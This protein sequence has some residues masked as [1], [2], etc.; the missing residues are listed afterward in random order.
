MSVECI[1]FKTWLRTGSQTLREAGVC[2]GDELSAV[3]GRFWWMA[4]Q[5]VVSK[6]RGCLFVAG[7]APDR[8]PSAR[9]MSAFAAGLNSRCDFTLKDVELT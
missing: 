8:G 7:N 3:A 9:F 6:V 4:D 1:G 2:D 5:T